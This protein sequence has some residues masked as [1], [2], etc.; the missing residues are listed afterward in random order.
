MFNRYFDSRLQNSLFLRRE[1]ENPMENWEEEM[2]SRTGAKR[3]GVP[4]PTPFR[5]RLHV[6]FPF[7]ERAWIFNL[8]AK[9]ETVLQ[10]ILIIFKCL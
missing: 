4:R 3:N 1:I 2:D 8:P 10:S 7:D 5:F 6:H 9:E